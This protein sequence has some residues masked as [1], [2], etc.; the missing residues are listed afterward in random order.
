[1]DAIVIENVTKSYDG[2]VNAVSGL[3]LTVPEGGVFGFLGPNGA[4]KTTTVKMLGGLLSPTAGA[5]RVCGFDS[6]QMPEKVHSVSS[7]MTEST[8]MYDHLTARENLRFFG[9]LFA[10]S[11]DEIEKR[12]AALLERVGLLDAGEKKLRAFSTGM[13]QRLSL[14]RVL[15]TRPKV[16]FLD[17][18]TSGL[19]P[20]SVRWVNEIIRE[21]GRSGATVFL[22]THQLRYAEEICTQYGLMAKGKLLASGTFEA[23]M[24]MVGSK[25]RIRVRGRNVPD[26]LMR[27]LA[28]GLYEQDAFG[29]ADAAAL[30]RRAIQ[31]GADI[32]EVQRQRDSLEDLYFS[33]LNQA[34]GDVPR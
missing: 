27:R 33:L 3:T 20:E 18:P 26:N 29:D 22:C 28:D 11:D 5:L 19:D 16:L 14:A 17:E 32:Y 9:R 6:A 34:E 1:M 13:R 15:L 12:S 21:Q 24:D 2:K 25:H 4:G 10:L 8:M 30:I 23:L 31:A 7:L